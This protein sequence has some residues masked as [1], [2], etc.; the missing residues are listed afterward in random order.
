MIQPWRMMRNDRS[1]DF[2]LQNLSPFRIL[3]RL[4]QGR[5]RSAE[6]ISLSCSVRMRPPTSLS[7]RGP[8]LLL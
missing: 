3:P 4:C 6:D 2:P 8:M 5:V 1:L 7:G